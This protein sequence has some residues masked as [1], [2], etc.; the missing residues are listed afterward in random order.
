M[1]ND[2][3]DFCDFYDDESLNLRSHVGLILAT[4][5]TLVLATTNVIF[6]TLATL[7]LETASVVLETLP[8]VLLALPH[9]LVLLR[10]LR[11]GLLKV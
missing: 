2:F 4:L 9:F 6:E 3:C 8:I 5:A 10:S 1:V 11:T 7:V